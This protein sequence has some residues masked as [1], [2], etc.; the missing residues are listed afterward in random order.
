MGARTPEQRE[1]FAQYWNKKV[2][3]VN[4]NGTRLP[5]AR[6]PASLPFIH[7][8]NTDEQVAIFM[9]RFQMHARCAP[10][11][12]LRKN[13]TTNVVEC[14]FFFPREL[15]ERALVT[16]SINKK[17]WMF[18]VERN[19]ERLAQCS[20][21]M[22]LEWL[23]NTD[24]QPAVTYKGLILYVAKYVSKPEIRSASYQELQEQVLPYVS[25]RRPIASLAARLLNKLIGERDWS[26]QEISHILLKIP[27]Q[28]STRQCMVLD[29]RPDQAQD[30]RIRF[31]D[32][33]AGEDMVVKE[34]LSAYKRY[35]LRIEHA[36]GG[37][38]LR[39]VT[40]I[41]WLQHYDASKFQRLSKGK[42]RTVTFFPHY[43]SNPTDD[44][45]E[46]YC[47]VKMMLSHPFEKVEDVL[48][49]DGFQAETYQEAY[50]LCCDS[51]NHVD[52]LY[53]E[54]DVDDDDT[55]FDAD[56]EFQDV[57]PSRPTPPAP[58]ADFETYGLAHTGNDAS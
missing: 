45:Y 38:R 47:R 42:P 56:E 22:A 48:E 50:E 16:K 29:C 34:G 25:D 28:K 20:P 6:N 26:A 1:A 41:D 36:S 30:R 31:D 3:A 46:D 58:L 40:L 19:M 37:E 54:L 13:K 49:V 55:E 27:Q 39:V 33:E 51:H 2:T 14:R 9:N 23:D 5:D 8:C 52:D 21:V 24:L 35:K 15:Q 43:K 7:I 18:G 4:P 44:E 12:C 11:R 17:S 53:D 10:G 57:N 32:G